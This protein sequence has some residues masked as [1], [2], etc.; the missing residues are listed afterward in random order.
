M[1]LLSNA[2]VSDGKLLLRIGHLAVE[3]PITADDVYND[4]LVSGFREFARSVRA[5]SDASL[6]FKRRMG[7]APRC[8]YIASRSVMV[9]RA[10]REGV[11][12]ASE[13]KVNPI[14]LAALIGECVRALEEHHTK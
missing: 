7:S 2:R 6:P 5:G 12:L 11:I 14:M 3:W 13:V 4:T 9:L 1:A 8:K 10:E